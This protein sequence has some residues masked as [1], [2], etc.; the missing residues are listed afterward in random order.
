MATQPNEFS[1][2]ERFAAWPCSLGAV[3]D[4]HGHAAM[5]PIAADRSSVRGHGTPAPR[6]CSTYQ[7]ND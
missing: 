4:L 5:A 7:T 1:R 6:A 2:Y 3:A